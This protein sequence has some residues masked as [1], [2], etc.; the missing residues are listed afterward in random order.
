MDNL[1]NNC[2]YCSKK[3]RILK[4]TD[5][6]TRKLHKKCWKKQR[7]EKMLNDFSRSENIRLLN[8]IKIMKKRIIFSEKIILENCLFSD[9]EL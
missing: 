9:D 4:K 2:E 1:K 5:W 3:L 7:Q 6:D 8:N